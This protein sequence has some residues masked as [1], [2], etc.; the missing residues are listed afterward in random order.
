MASCADEEKNRADYAEAKSAQ[1]FFKELIESVMAGKTDEF[2]DSLY[3]YLETRPHINAED[4]IREF[5]SEGKT[6]LHLASSSGHVD[7]LRCVLAY[8]SDKRSFV[9][10]QDKDGFSPL[11]YATISE[12]IECIRELVSSGADVNLANK[13]GA[14]PI[15]FAAGDGSLDRASF[16][17]ENGA[18]TQLVSNSGSA[19]HWA[20]GKGQ[21]EMIKY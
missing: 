20:A 19:L 1:G 12:S 10:I 3:R 14:A 6:V 21:S 13:D 17:I 7:I 4:V 15:H 9:N 11:I 5:Q 2:R 18:N 16:L 8:I